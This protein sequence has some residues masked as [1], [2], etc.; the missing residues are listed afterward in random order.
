MLIGR[1]SVMKYYTTDYTYCN[2]PQM[3]YTKYFEAY[4]FVICTCYLVFVDTN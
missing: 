2:A 3:L 4:I 1:G